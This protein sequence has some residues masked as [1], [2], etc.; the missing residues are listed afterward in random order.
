MGAWV[1]VV[2]HLNIQARPLLYVPAGVELK[3][4]GLTRH[5]VPTASH[6]L[7]SVVLPIDDL[8]SGDNTAWD[9]DDIRGGGNSELALFKLLVR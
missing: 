1:Y 2:R 7:C 3:I 5:H 6:Y 9:R 8:W 4:W